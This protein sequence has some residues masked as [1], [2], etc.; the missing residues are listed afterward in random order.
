MDDDNILIHQRV[1]TM[2]CQQLAR[3]NDCQMLPPH[4]IN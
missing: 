2:A 4:S 3:A 1:V